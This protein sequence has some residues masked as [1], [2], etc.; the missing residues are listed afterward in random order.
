MRAILAL[1]ALVAL[2][3]LIGGAGG[4]LPASAVHA[5]IQE[6]TSVPA[7]WEGR[8]VSVT[9]TVADRLA[10]LGY[11]GFVLQDAAGRQVV[12]LGQS[13]PAAPGQTMQVEG[14]FVTAIAVGNLSMAAVLVGGD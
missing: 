3:V 1:A 12:V 10:V 8:Q 2:A 9:G 4:T 6:L 5:S 13:N 11:G 7:A 14:T